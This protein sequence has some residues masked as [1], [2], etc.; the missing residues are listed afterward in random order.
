MRLTISPQVC[1]KYNNFTHALVREHGGIDTNIY[2]VIIEHNIT[3]LCENIIY[4]DN[5]YQ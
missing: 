1:Y 3:V 4:N 5:H 2:P